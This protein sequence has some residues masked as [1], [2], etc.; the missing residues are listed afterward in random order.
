MKDY[1]KVLGVEKDASQDDI[2]KKYRKIAFKY[3][4]DKAPEDKK[5]EYEEKFKEV[6]EAYSVLSDPQKR[7]QYD[8]PHSGFDFGGFGMSVEDIINNF[9]GGRS[10]FDPFGRRRG[11][12]NNIVVGK[13]VK[14]DT[15]ISFED[16]VKGCDK[17]I[18]YSRPIHCESCNGKGYPPEVEPET[19]KRC[20]GTG[21]VESRNGFTLISYTC[22]DCSGSGNIIKERCKDCNGG[23]VNKKASV[24]INI[25][26]GVNNGT[27]FKCSGA[28][29]QGDIFGDLLIRVRV[30]EHPHF[31]RVHNNIVS[32]LRIDFTEAILGAEKRVDTV[33]GNRKV[34]IFPGTQHG[35]SIKIK[36][37]GIRGSDHVVSVIVDIPKEITEKQRDVLEKFH[38]SD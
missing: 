27:I 6:A 7:D 36:G 18:K 16:M 22:P 15:S 28:G 23:F 25:P 8:N 3:H 32:S 21:M 31:H 9:M 4:P 5:Q 2:K 24:K 38:D 14:L 26:P 17:E 19:C 11:R 33:F 37:D 30:Q 35:D 10:G 12:K 34:K 29:G 20:N 1:Y 13:I